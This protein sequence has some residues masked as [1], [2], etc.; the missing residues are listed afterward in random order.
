[1]FCSVIWILQY[2]ER[3]NLHIKHG[4]ILKLCNKAFEW[5]TFM[6]KK[7]LLL[8]TLKQQIKTF[9]YLAQNKTRLED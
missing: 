9:I 8:K 6:M 7:K 3:E 4:N 1:M 2:R 5:K